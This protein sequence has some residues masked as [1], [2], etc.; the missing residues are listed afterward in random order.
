MHFSKYDER[1][2]NE[3]HFFKV[4]HI[5]R[6]PFLLLHVSA[7]Q[8]CRLQGAQRI[9]MKLCV[10]YVISHAYDVAYAQLRQESF[11]LPKDGAP[12]APKHVGARLMF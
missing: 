3:M 9:L 12:A 10:C 4:N 2:T 6:I 11:G 5:F 7:L 1:K 8:E